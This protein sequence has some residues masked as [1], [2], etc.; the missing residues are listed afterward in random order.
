MEETKKQAP[1]MVV[2]EVETP[3]APATT[4]GPTPEVKTEVKEEPKK[5]QPEK[6]PSPNNFNIMWILIP[7]ILLLGLLMGGIFAYYRG[8]SRLNNLTSTPTPTPFS[9]IPTPTPATNKTN[10]TKYSIKVLN[11]SGIAGEA[12][13]VKTLLEN[14][15]FK[16]A[17]AANAKTYDYEKTEI[18][19]KQ[20]IETD[21]IQALVSA[22][23]KAYQMADPTTSATQSASIIVTVGSLKAK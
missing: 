18:S 13:K 1:K 12:G 14:A 21:F 9:A 8:I 6:K 23:G 15:G 4:P 22:L 5:E 20:G 17:S 10:L 3:A 19:T 11:G 16:V 2:E 7:G